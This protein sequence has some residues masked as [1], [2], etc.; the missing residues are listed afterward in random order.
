MRSNFPSAL[1]NLGDGR[2]AEQGATTAF[3]PLERTITAIDSDQL[4]LNRVESAVGP[5]T[6]ERLQEMLAE[7]G[8]VE[9]WEYHTNRDGSQEFTG[10]DA[11]GGVYYVH[12]AVDPTTPEERVSVGKRSSQ[13]QPAPDW[14]ITYHQERDDQGRD[15]GIKLVVTD[16]IPAGPESQG[17]IDYPLQY[18]G[19]EGYI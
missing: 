19:S 16:T 12:K 8:I 17:S 10:M 6:Q 3:L 7:T 5:V 4:R 13:I 11:L 2:S 1:D 15:L 9:K 14:T 18:D